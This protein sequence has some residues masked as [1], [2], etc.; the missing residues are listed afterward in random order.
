MSDAKTDI[1]LPLETTYTLN[2][3]KKIRIVKTKKESFLAPFQ[4]K[5][6]VS[7]KIAMGI[8]EDPVLLKFLFLRSKSTPR[9]YGSLETTVTFPLVLE[10]GYNFKKNLE[11]RE[12]YQ[13]RN[14]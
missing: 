14:E 4:Y 1:T 5:D 13:R 9:F 6:S 2:D 10:P 8:A 11:N 12:D 3:G 7:N